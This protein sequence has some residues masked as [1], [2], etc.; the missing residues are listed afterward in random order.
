MLLKPLLKSSPM[1]SMFNIHDTAVTSGDRAGS[2]WWQ[3]VLNAQHHSASWLVRFSLF[4]WVASI[5]TLAIFTNI[6]VKQFEEIHTDHPIA[7]VL[8]YYLAS[9]FWPMSLVGHSCG[10][11][12]GS[13]VLVLLLIQMIVFLVLCLRFLAKTSG[14]TITF[15]HL[16]PAVVVFSINSAMT[17][18][19]GILHCR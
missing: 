14:S 12:Y 18:A 6:L 4:L 19:V 13:I 5:P 16:L 2:S 8:H 17:W 15:R 9:I 3:G 7:E 11:S 10:P 1:K